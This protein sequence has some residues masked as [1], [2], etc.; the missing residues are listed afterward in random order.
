MA[1]EKNLAA[2][3]AA[4][5]GNSLTAE[6]DVPVNY[7]ANFEGDEIDGTTYAMG[8]KITGLD[9]G[10]AAYLVQNGRITPTSDDSAGTPAGGSGGDGITP[11]GAS[12]GDQEVTLSDTEQAEADTLVADNSAAD[13]QAMLPEGSSKSGSKADLAARIIAG[14]R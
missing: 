8:D 5:F 3:D 6:S 11:P 12:A 9:A 1:D 7:V 2:D 10:T 14:R 13:L 4:N